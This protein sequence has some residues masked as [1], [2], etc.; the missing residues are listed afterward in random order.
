[1]QPRHGLGGGEGGG[2][3]GD[4]KAEA[5]AE[6]SAGGGRD[7]GFGLAAEVGCRC[8]SREAARAAGAAGGAVLVGTHHKTGTVLLQQLMMDLVKL[9]PKFPLRLGRQRYSILQSFLQGYSNVKTTRQARSLPGS[10]RR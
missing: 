4:V 2:G 6:G 5:E 10:T 7:L 1:M 9:H 3:D 8:P